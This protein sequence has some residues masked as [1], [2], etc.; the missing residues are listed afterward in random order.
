MEEVQL[1]K[2]MN[3]IEKQQFQDYAGRVISYMEENGRNTYPMKKV[4][5][6]HYLLQYLILYFK[7]GLC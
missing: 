7:I 6:L 5:I 3:D 2:H 1:D 4:C